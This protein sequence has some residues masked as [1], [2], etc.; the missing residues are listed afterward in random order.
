MKNWPVRFR[1]ALYFGVAFLP[2]FVDL[3]ADK[4]RDD[5]WPSPQKA[6][7]GALLGCYAGLVALRAYYDGS[8]QR[9]EDKKTL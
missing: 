7:L 8:A 2:A 6:T 1:A 4:L 5:V 3:V 9:H